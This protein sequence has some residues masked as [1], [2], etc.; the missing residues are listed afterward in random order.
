MASK[1]LIR[2]QKKHEVKLSKDGHLAQ[3]S[4]AHDEPVP[5]PVPESIRKGGAKRT[6]TASTPRSA[7]LT[8]TGTRTAAARGKASLV[9]DKA[10]S[11]AKKPSKAPRPQRERTEKAAPSPRLRRWTPIAW[12]RWPAS[13]GPSATCWSMHC[14]RTTTARC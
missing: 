14:P 4:K 10:P 7:S 1:T 5:L 9:S 13:S 2:S 12:R 3:S 6:S 8:G 11:Q